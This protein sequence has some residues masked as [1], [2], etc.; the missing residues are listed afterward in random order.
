MEDVNRNVD[1]FTHAKVWA[2]GRALAIGS[3]NCTEAGLNISPKAKNNVEAGII[4]QLSGS[5]K[6]YFEDSFKLKILKNPILSTQEEL[7]ADSEG[8]LEDFFFTISL[9][10]NWTSLRIGLSNVESADLIHEK[11]QPDDVLI[12]PGIGKC[13]P[14]GLVEGIDVREYSTNFLA[15]RSYTFE[16]KE[17]KILYRGYLL[18]SGLDERPAQRFKDID[19]YLSGWIKGRPEEQTFRHRLNYELVLNSSEDLED[20]TRAILSTASRNTW[21]TAFF[22][23]DQIAF[24][25]R[26]VKKNYTT[27]KERQQEFIRLGRTLPGNLTELKKHLEGILELFLQEP[28]QF[29]QSPIYLWFLIEKANALFELF[30]QESEMEEEAISLLSNFQ[31]ENYS[32]LGNS[33]DNISGAVKKWNRFIT[34]KLND[35]EWNQ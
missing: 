26:S 2:C 5:Y 22:A 33:M 9:E 28:D 30:N 21:F 24:R 25:I 31:W 29:K 27:K 4:Y 14:M 35:W 16:T 23:F 8:I 17:G 7:E 12:L 34:N 32:T 15:D 11:L 13:S 1:Q 10:L 20:K 18:E 3:W 6:S 19:D